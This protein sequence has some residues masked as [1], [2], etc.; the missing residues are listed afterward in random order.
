[1]DEA[2]L[3]KVDLEHLVHSGR[4]LRHNLATAL[5]IGMALH[6]EDAGEAGVRVV[7]VHLYAVR[8]ADHA[9]L[10]LR[11]Y[12]PIDGRSGICQVKR[13][14]WCEKKTHH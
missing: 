6:I 10:G 4:F 1:M 12:V 11:E 8:E 14:D 9:Y 3:A 13:S 7:D 2:A 5:V